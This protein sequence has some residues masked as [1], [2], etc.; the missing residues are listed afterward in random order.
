VNADVDFS[1]DVYREP[2]STSYAG[3][4]AACAG[5]VSGISSFSFIAVKL[6]LAKLPAAL[7]EAYPGA[8]WLG[9]IVLPCLSSLANSRSS[10]AGPDRQ[11]QIR[12]SSGFLHFIPS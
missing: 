7:H 10:D 11:R 6:G 2:P 9:G 8:A 5:Q 1:E 4:I 12:D 3:V